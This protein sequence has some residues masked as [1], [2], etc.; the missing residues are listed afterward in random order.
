MALQKKDAFPYRVNGCEEV[1]VAALVGVDVSGRAW[2]V[3]RAV[4]A[5]GSAVD[6]RQ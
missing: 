5:V 6:E 1:V 4:A 3:A 2:Q